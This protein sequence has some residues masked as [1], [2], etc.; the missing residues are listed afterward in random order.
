MEVNVC[1]EQEDVQFQGQGTLEQNE[2]FVRLQF[3]YKG[4][5]SEVVDVF[6]EHERQTDCILL[7]EFSSER[8]L[9][10]IICPH[11]EEGYIKTSAGLLVFEVKS[12]DIV[13]TEK[14]TELSYHLSYH[15]R[16]EIKTASLQEVH[17]HIEKKSTQKNNL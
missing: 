13:R 9:Y 11:W 12:Q 8:E 4:E 1:L 5:G 7:R 17:L 14:E 6:F 3:S 10:I 2:D 16:Q 15:L